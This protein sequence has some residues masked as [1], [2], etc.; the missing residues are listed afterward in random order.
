MSDEYTFDGYNELRYTPVPDEFF[1]WQMQGM[2]VAELRVMLYIFRRTFGFKKHQ[3]RIALS[4]FT[5][6]I[7]KRTGEKLDNGCGLSSKSVRSGIDGLVKK[8]YVGAQFYC[9]DCKRPIEE[10][11]MVQE[12]RT[13]KT[14][15]GPEPYSVTV[16]PKVCPDC[17]HNLL[18]REQRYFC[19]VMNRGGVHP[20][21]TGV[22]N[23]VTTGCV[24]RVHHKKQYQETVN[25]THGADAPSPLPDNLDDFF[26]PAP[27]RKP[28]ASTPHWT[29]QVQEAN[30]EWAVW[31]M[32]SQAFQDLLVQ[33]EHNGKKVQE[34]GAALERM[35]GL[36][37]LWDD[38][39]S[40][41]GWCSG[42]WQCLRETEMDVEVIEEAI[43]QLIYADMSIT[44]PWSV[45]NTA[46]ALAAARRVPRPEHAGLDSPNPI[47]A[48]RRGAQ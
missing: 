41:K 15:D 44:D 9:P 31:G 8:G 19:L 20:S 1:D 25:K 43:M 3:D 2:S 27:E 21:N 33:Y 32:Q 13:R 24:T 37:P 46:R 17:K 12:V 4:Q 40:V 29:I 23:E 10:D 28:A 47:L 22:C 26:G 42:L 11:E 38:K 35:T 16:V 5:N 6:G 14:E 7:C 18:G 45:V 48:G 36:H 39:K 30:A 34:V